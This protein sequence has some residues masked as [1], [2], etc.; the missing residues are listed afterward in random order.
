M[1]LR[2]APELFISNRYIYT[3]EHIEDNIFICEA[4]VWERE[5]LIGVDEL[6]IVNLLVIKFSEGTHLYIRAKMVN[7]KT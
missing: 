2:S 6:Q 7:R 4:I 3:L 5:K 1:P